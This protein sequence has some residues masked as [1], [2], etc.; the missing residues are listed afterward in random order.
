MRN[1][2][3]PH[4]TSVAVSCD[5]LISNMFINQ[6]SIVD[7]FALAAESSLFE[8]IATAQCVLTA[9]G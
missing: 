5:G 3:Q 9:A 1:V 6:L 7:A 8:L 2:S 4:N